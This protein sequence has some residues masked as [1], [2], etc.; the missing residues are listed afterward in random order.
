MPKNIE[1]TL[2]HILFL[3]RRFHVS[4]IKYIAMVLILELGIDPK[5]DGYNYLLKA[6]TM[7]LEAPSKLSIKNLYSAIA[8]LYNGAIDE[9]Q[10]EQSIRSAIKHAWDRRDNETWGYYFIFESQEEIGKPSNG[11]FI[12]MVAC[13]VELWKGWSKEYE[14]TCKRG[15]GFYEGI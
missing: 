5:Y 8:A 15:R 9:D 2:D 12:S 4:E 6:I 10:V 14:K 13:I 3:A 7:Y 11:E 1:K